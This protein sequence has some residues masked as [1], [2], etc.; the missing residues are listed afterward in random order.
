MSDEDAFG[1]RMYQ[2]CSLSACFREGLWSASVENRVVREHAP[3]FSAKDSPAHIA[4]ASEKRQQE[5][6]LDYDILT[7]MELV[8]LLKSE[9]AGAWQYVLER[10]LVQEKHCAANNRK[11]QDWNVCLESFMGPLYEDMVGERKLDLFSGKGSLIGWLRRYVRG[12]LSRENP[13]DGRS[14]SL[15]ET[16]EDVDGECQNTLSDKVAKEASEKHRS[17]AYAGEG[18]EVLRREQLQIANKCFRD[19]W[20]GNSMQAYVML[21]KT[22]FQMSSLEIKER[23]GISSVA[24]VDQMFSRAVKR[25]KELKVKHDC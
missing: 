10:I 11:R 20:L 7:D 14:V 3:C 21:L 24:N 13:D 12:Y 2:A 17:N 18:S 16:I 9:S 23:L 25:M 22:R 6:R 4:A 1:I 15:D 8:K 5:K 19:L